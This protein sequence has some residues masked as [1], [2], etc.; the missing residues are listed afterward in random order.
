MHELSVTRMIDAPPARVW[1]VMVNRTNEW[2]CPKPW[3]AEV[4]FGERKPGSTMHTVMHGPDG[5]VE[6]HGGIILAWDEGQHF[7]TTDAIQEGLQPG[8]PFMIGI[9][10][11]A[12]DGQGS[13]YTALARHWTAEAMEQH[14]A[15]GFA[16][17]WGACAGQLK[18]LCE[19]A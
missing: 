5:E 2:W 17:G 8:T 16:E 15:M 14:K 10:E 12:P 11:V 13:R 9:W 18:A 6:R 1:G 19:S 7:A 4:D 3:R